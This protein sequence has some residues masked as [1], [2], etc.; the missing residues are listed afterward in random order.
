[1]PILRVL[2]AVE[3]VLVVLAFGVFGW[4]IYTQRQYAAVMPRKPDSTTGRIYPY[5]AH[6]FHVYV[7]RQEADRGRLAEFLGPFA[8]I[9]AVGGVSLLR[10]TAKR[11]EQRS[12]DQP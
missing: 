7:T 4:L 6:R 12:K 5:T 2:K 8:L 3:R 1:M 11:L 9:C 10:W